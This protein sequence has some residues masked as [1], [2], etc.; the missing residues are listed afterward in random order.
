MARSIIHTSSRTFAQPAFRKRFS[1]SPVHVAL[2]VEKLFQLALGR[3]IY[4]RLP[5]GG[6]SHVESLRLELD[7]GTASEMTSVDVFEN[8]LCFH[9][10]TAPEAQTNLANSCTHPC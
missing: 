10:E 5:S 8:V 3:D 7:L 1:A 6:I 2:D 9:L 4:V